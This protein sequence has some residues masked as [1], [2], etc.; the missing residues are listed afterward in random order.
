MQKCHN[1]KKAPGIRKP[2]VCFVECQVLY[3]TVIPALD[4]GIFLTLDCRVYAR[5]WQTA[6]YSNDKK[7]RIYFI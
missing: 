5:Q 4:V 2:K 7:T 6:Y 1:E 3:F